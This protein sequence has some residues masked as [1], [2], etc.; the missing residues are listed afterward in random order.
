LDEKISSQLAN[1]TTKNIPRATRKNGKSSIKTA[2]RTERIAAG[3][4]MMARMA[5]IMAKIIFKGRVIRKIP[6]F[7]AKTS[8]F[9]KIIPISSRIKSPIISMGKPFFKMVRNW[10]SEV[11][12]LYTKINEKPIFLNRS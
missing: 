12:K 7:R 8:T 1:F 2:P 4:K 3:R 5:A 6:V 11:T 10:Y 9:K